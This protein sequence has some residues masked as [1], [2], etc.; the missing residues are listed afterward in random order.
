MSHPTKSNFTHEQ[1]DLLVK[2]KEMRRTVLDMLN[3]LGNDLEKVQ[4]E[5]IELRN[6]NQELLSEISL[7][8]NQIH[9]LSWDNDRLRRER[10]ELMGELD[11]TVERFRKRRRIMA[12]SP[13]SPEGSASPQPGRTS[14]N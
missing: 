13:E 3:K 1:Q 4:G 2:H 6:I 12:D 8:R 7:L 9:C 11:E 5:N 10:Q 14:N